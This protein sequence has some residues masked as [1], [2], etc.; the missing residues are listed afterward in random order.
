M[1]RHDRRGDLVAVEPRYPVPL[2][3]PSQQAYTDRMARRPK[4]APL[5]ISAE[6]YRCAEGKA[7]L[8]YLNADDSQQFDIMRT[9]WSQLN[10]DLMHKAHEAVRSLEKGSSATNKISPL[11]VAA[12]I[13]FDK[14]Y[15][16]RPAVVQPL[17]FPQPLIAMVKRGLELANRVRSPEPVREPEQDGTVRATT[18]LPSEAVLSPEPRLP[19]PDRRHVPSEHQQ[20][21]VSAREASERLLPESIRLKR[22]QQRALNRER[23]AAG[24]ALRIERLRMGRASSAPPA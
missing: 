9:K 11:I 20:A 13:G 23:L 3:I 5:P 22:E 10:W 16:K 1:E 6:D 24:R 14:L 15:A 7:F 2:D 17:S 18:I 12:G 8:A 19:A 21:I 4:L